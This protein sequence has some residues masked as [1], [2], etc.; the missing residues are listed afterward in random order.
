MGVPRQ[1]G[2]AR[3]AAHRGTTG[4]RDLL[5]Q[6]VGGSAGEGSG[7]GICDPDTHT[8]TNTHSDQDTCE[9]HNPIARPEWVF[10]TQP[11]ETCTLSGILEP[12]LQLGASARSSE[13]ERS[14]EGSTSSP[15]QEV[16]PCG[17]HVLQLANSGMFA[18]DQHDWPFGCF[19]AGRIRMVE[20]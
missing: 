11:Q 6:Y 17:T 8:H 12:R 16:I 3:S 19:R 2:A 13:L 9:E 10:A 18:D 15:V 4:A 5:A 7:R 14:R 20:T 1:A